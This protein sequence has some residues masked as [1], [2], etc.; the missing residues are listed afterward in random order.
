KTIDQKKEVEIKKI[1]S[2]KEVKILA[3][4][5]RALKEIAKKKAEVLSILNKEKSGQISEFLQKEETKLD[6]II[7]EEKNKII[8]EVWNRAE[9]RIS[10]MPEDSFRDI[11][12][13]LIKFVPKEMEGE[14]RASERTAKIL[15]KSFEK[16]EI[17]ADL[18]EE[19]FL[20]KTK[21]LDLD[22][23]IK[24]VLKQMKEDLNPQIIK[25][26]FAK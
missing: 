12:N 8:E 1:E 22:F 17:K 20:V 13:F 23:R 4:K 7:Q 19:G 2:E 5:E 3:L 6:F 9:E 16:F 11:I 18:K 10:Q 14:I 25:I 24:E 21:N 26:L 15:G